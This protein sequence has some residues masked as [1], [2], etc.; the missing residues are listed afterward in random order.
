M[1]AKEMLEHLPKRY[2]KKSPNNKARLQQPINPDF[3]IDVH[4]K[5]VNNCLQY[6]AD[7]TPFMQK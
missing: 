2:G 6:A 3:P 4:F 5:C 1:T 7:A